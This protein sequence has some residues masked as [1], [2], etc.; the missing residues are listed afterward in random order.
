M[1]KEERVVKFVEEL[2][3]LTKKYGLEITAQGAEPYLFDL[4]ER[5]YAPYITYSDR[6]E[7]YETHED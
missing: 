2:T 3:E 7:K 5:D 6:L 4:I 1:K